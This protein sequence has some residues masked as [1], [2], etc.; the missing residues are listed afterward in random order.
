MIP[1]RE[2]IE[3]AAEQT[4][5]QASS[6]EK[7]VMLGDLAA[8]I[9]RHPLMKN[10]LLLKGG[11]ALNLGFGPPSRLAVDLD[12]NYVGHLDREKTLQDRPYTKRL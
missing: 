8:D 10:G 5:Y 9:S 12:F 11:T 4:G 1:S 6:L 2:F 7:V 3:Q